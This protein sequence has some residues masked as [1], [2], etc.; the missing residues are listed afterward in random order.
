MS[1]L[2]TIKAQL[3]DAY[4]QK[5]MA[6]EKIKALRNVLAGIQVAEEA[7]KQKPAEEAPAE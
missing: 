1:A 7:V 6:E 5:E 2:E 4:V 3:L